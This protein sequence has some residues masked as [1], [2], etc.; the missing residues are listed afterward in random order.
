MLQVLVPAVPAV[1]AVPTL[2]GLTVSSIDEYEVMYHRSQ[3]AGVSLLNRDRR[4]QCVWGS[5]GCSFGTSGAGIHSCERSP[6]FFCGWLCEPG[7]REI[8]F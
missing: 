2:P 5:S 3:D 8:S 7:P 1:P 6:A 4:L